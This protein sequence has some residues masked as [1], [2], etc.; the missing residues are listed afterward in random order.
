MKTLDPKAVAKQIKIAVTNWPGNCYAIALAMV[1]A[2]V[3]PKGARAVYGHYLGKV[4]KKSMFYARSHVGFCRHGWVLLKDGT[5]VDPTRWVFEC[6]DPYIFIGRSDEYDEGGNSLRAALVRPPPAFDDIPEGMDPK[7]YV[8]REVKLR[9]TKAA[10][11]HVAN[12]FQG[13]LREDCVVSNIQLFWIANLPLQMLQ[14]HAKAIYTAL[15][16]AGR[17]G[18][19]PIDN[20]RAILGDKA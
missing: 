15:V 5:V 1:N 18:A 14:P 7:H 11:E 19:I 9:F 3:V 17:D 20:R 10:E 4:A 6:S 13:L 2:G 16:K 8:K 12:L